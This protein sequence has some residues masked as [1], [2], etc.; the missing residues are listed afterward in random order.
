MPAVEICD[1]SEFINGS[2]ESKQTHL[3]SQSQK[4]HKNLFHAFLTNLKTIKPVKTETLVK[5]LQ[6]P[7]RFLINIYVFELKSVLRE[8]KM[9]RINLDK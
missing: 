2:D 3:I 5:S 4:C 9:L 8:R 1:L 7:D 6:H